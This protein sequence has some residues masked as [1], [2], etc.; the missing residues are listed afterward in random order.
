MDRVQRS[1][2]WLGRH[3]ALL[4]VLLALDL[5]GVL[6]LALS[7]FGSAQER[8]LPVNDL[9]GLLALTGV[10]TPAPAPVQDNPQPAL[11]AAPAATCGPGSRPLAGE[12]GRVPATAINSPAAASG[13]T[14]NTSVVGH[15]GGQPGGF[16]VWRYVDHSGHVC[17]FYDTSIVSPANVFSLAAGP[18]PGVEVL[19][20]GNP[21][22]PTPTAQL[23]S[24]PM[25]SPHES[26]NLNARRG[27]LAADMGNGTALPG[28]MSIYDV[29]RDCRHPVLDSTY[30]AARFG[31]E[32]GFSPDGR[33]FYIGGAAGIAAVDV[34][35]PTHPHT[36]WEGNVY[37]HGLN[38]SDDGNTLYDADP[39]NGNLVLLDVS[40]IQAR[41]PNPVVREISRLTWDTVSIPQ[42]TNPM[43]IGGHRY[44]L[45]FDEFAFRFSAPPPLE[46]LDQVGGARI[47][48]IDDPAHPR[49]VSNLRLAVNMPAA[50]K[51]ADSD[52]S[53]LPA[54]LT[55]YA[56]HY[57][58]I[59]REVDPE[60]VA[61]SFI[62]SGLRVFNIQD[63]LRPREVGYYISPPPHGPVAG[64]LA[65][66]QPAFDPARREVW[67][68]DA[69]TGFYVLG[70]SAAAWPQP[71]AAHR[72]LPCAAPTGSLQGRRLGPA[73][74]GESRAAERRRLRRFKVFRNPTYDRLC[75]TPR[76]GLRVG[77][78]S[79][80]LLRG[81]SRPEA[82]RIRGRA[83]MLL[84]A[85]RHYALHAI[86]PGASLAAARRRLHLGRGFAIGRNTWYL[87]PGR[88]SNG[89][90]KVH[91][92]MVEEV[93]VADRALRS[94]RIGTRRFLASF[95]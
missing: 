66:S 17:A 83:I 28:L 37:A 31:H 18:S 94:G 53:P 12:Q 63:P 41:K 36:V 52:P 1:L 74:L 26:L 42:N 32:S 2:S 14:C 77:Y 5:A 39:V 88:L 40:Q 59:P 89:V 21:A 75:L 11:A 72:P 68:T 49:V 87:V 22:H 47:V 54:P 16:R 60:I 6:M 48:N 10:P 58:A 82:H 73:R 92:G 29:S 76:P 9:E 90:L 27:L 79:P 34:S 51:I 84:T 65:M 55:N 3:R 80:S 23:T 71:P 69:T 61:C 8:T 38:V 78:P 62:N 25:L 85:N 20:L 56:S 81:L 33:T 93:G 4:V 95:R 57:C 46:P 44:L 24:L 45:E 67:Y 64:D 70:L 86:R 35:D 15:F 50:H 91:R 13:W 43:E 7:G 30:L 19:D